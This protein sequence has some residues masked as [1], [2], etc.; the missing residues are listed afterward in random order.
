VLLLSN[1]DVNPRRSTAQL[2][3]KTPSGPE[4]ASSRKGLTDSSRGARPGDRERL[5]QGDGAA[6]KPEPGQLHCTT[7]TGD[8]WQVAAEIIKPAGAGKFHNP[9]FDPS[10]RLCAE[11]DVVLFNFAERLTG[12]V[13]RE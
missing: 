4:G 1:G 13:L 6:V 11:C 3:T 12:A 9:D 7:T 5:Q 2:K 10:P 8:A